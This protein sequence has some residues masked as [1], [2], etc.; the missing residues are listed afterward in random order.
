MRTI[1][2]RIRK[3]GKDLESIHR[4]ID[5][6]PDPIRGQMKVQIQKAFEAG[7]VFHE[8]QHVPDAPP[9]DE[10]GALRIGPALMHHVLTM[11]KV[12]SD[13]NDLKDIVADIFEE[14]SQSVL[15]S[16]VREDRQVVSGTEVAE[17]T[18]AD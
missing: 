4:T 17:I 14:H 13:L 6:L 16:I 2:K 11:R 5:D 1:R 9:I 7:Q 10:T 8:L 15:R 3:V 18:I 12:Y